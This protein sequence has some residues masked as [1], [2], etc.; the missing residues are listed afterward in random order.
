MTSSV[1]RLPRVGQ[2]FQNLGL[3][4]GELLL[5]VQVIVRASPAIR[6]YRA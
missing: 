3:G 2:G 4:L 1:Q 6:S 5:P